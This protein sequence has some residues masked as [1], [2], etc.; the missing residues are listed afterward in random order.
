MTNNM[1][2]N[3]FRNTLADLRDCHEHLHDPLIAGHPDGEHAARIKLVALCERI[4]EEC[5]VPADRPW[6]ITEHEEQEDLPRVRK[7]GES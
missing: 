4:L 3:R 1:S 6:Q 2:Y 7:M 5:G